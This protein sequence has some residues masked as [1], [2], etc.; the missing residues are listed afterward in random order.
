M[1]D[2]VK[3]TETL[4]LVAEV[5]KTTSE[6]MEREEILGYFKEM[7]LTREQEEM[8]I[9]YYEQPR[10][11]PAASDLTE[12]D[13]GYEE[14]GNSQIL[15]MYLEEIESL[16]KYTEQ[17]E[18]ALYARLIAGEEVV[19]KLLSD[20]WLP[21]VLE[22]AEKRATAK[23]SLE[24][25]I[26]EGNIGLFLK[27]EELL[28]CEETTDFQKEISDAVEEAMWSYIAESGL[29]EDGN[30]TVLGKAALVSEAKNQLTG[31]LDREPTVKELAE[32]TKMDEEE[33]QGI[34]EL[35]RGT[36]GK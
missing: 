18:N 13:N 12:S 2:R 1:L 8:V 33:L 14:V 20:C 15:Q 16:P 21:R 30:H 28:G 11:D 36:S 22:L 3:F 19:V 26:Q 10:E 31:E 32:Y 34:L 4:Q 7:E 23:V 17:E 9:A 5:M 24:D 6:P 35:V 29:E 25:V 27:L